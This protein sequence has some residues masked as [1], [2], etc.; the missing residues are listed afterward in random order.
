M[1]VVVDEE[2]EVFWED[3]VFEEVVFVEDFVSEASEVVFLGLP[4]FLGTASAT[5]VALM[6]GFSRSMVMLSTLSPSCTVKCR[7][8]RLTTLYGPS[9]KGSSGFFCPSRRTNT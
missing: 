1:E 4:R 6:T 9:Y 8:P 5:G 3:V 7:L 2:E